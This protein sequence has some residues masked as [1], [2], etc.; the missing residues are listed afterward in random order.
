MYQQEG[1]DE[2]QS[3][4]SYI[5]DELKNSIEN[6]AL[7]GGKEGKLFWLHGD[8]LNHLLSMNPMEEHRKTM[9][10]TSANTTY[11]IDNQNIICQHNKDRQKYIFSI[12]LRFI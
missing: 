3:V 4:I 12:K 11:I 7:E 2:I 1:N 6:I 5:K 8:G 10:K 9:N